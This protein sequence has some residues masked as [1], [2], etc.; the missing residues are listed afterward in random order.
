MNDSGLHDQIEDLELQIEA[1]AAAAERCRKI[2]VASKLAIGIGGMWLAAII[3]GVVWPNAT[4]LLGS[5]TSMIAGVVVL[6]SNSSTWQE[7]TAKLEAAEALRTEL[8]GRIEL[9]VV[10]APAL[11]S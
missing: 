4:G 5:M 8:I 9:R 10:S 3:V 7:L 1:L 2:S 6:G 11:S